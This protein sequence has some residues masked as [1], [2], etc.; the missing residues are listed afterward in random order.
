MKLPAIPAFVLLTGN[1]QAQKMADPDS[2]SNP[3]TVQHNMRLP[4]AIPLQIS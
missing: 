4:V 2:L 3:V 1:L